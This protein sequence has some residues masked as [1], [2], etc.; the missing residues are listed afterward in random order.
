VYNFSES[1]FPALRRL[2][3]FSIQYEKEFDYFIGIDPSWSGRNPTA[4]VV[5]RENREIGRLSLYRYVY[6][7]ALEEIVEVVSELK[8]PSVIGVDAPLIVKNLQGHRENE[9]EFL[10]N[11][12]IKVP[13]YPVNT[14][15]Y[16]EFFPSA[17]YEKL[18]EIGFSFANNNVYEVYPHA[19]L[20]AKFFG[21]LFS[22]KRGKRK[23]RLRKLEKIERKLS[24]YIEFCGTSFGCVKERED[25]DDALI[26]ALTVYLPTKETCLGFGDISDGI[27]L[28]PIPTSVQKEQR[29][30][31]Q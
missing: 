2:F 3:M 7:K 18:N 19:T 10:K 28:V 21:K 13:L 26:C 1:G 25:F 24:E 23:E 5:L 6:A 9:L 30:D 8:R 17:L 11:Y 31:I 14:E 4:V 22:Y 27:L 15:R 12:P 16:P 29:E 20:A